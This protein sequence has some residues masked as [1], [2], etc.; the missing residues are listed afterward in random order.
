MWLLSHLTGGLVALAV[1]ATGCGDDDADLLVAAASDLQPVLEPLV[2]DLE[3]EH[4]MEI[5][6]SLGSTG[7][8]AQQLVGGAPF[9]L[10]L[11]ADTRAIDEVIDA[12]RGDPGTREVYAF[13]RLAVWTRAD[14]ASER[15]DAPKLA[16]LPELARPVAIANPEHAPYGVAARQALEAAGVAD[17]LDGRLLLAASV[18][19]AHRLARSGDAGAAVTAASLA[20]TDGDAGQWTLV[21]ADRHD[22]I[23]QELVVTA[24]DPARARSAERLM[25]ALTGPRGR[26]RLTELGFDLPG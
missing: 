14:E 21:E 10:F 7:Q 22:A 19:D 1:I 13:G 16:S 25:A 20:I 11:A 24:T 15:A 26:A 6:V 9:D 4:G 2:A 12:G 18:L 17:D 3:A 8:L 23:S 5:T